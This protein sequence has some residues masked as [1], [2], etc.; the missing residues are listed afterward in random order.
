MGMSTKNIFHVLV[1]PKEEF[2][3]AYYLKTTW[4]SQ[5]FSPSK[6]ECCL[7]LTAS[8]RLNC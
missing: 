8:N 2:N 7:F 1:I 5:S 4:S 3:E 6:K